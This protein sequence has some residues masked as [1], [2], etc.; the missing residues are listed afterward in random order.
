MYG[1]DFDDEDDWEVDRTYVDTEDLTKKEIKNRY[2]E[3]D[4]YNYD[5]FV[6]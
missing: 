6:E 3:D 1:I 4:I 5:D 2:G